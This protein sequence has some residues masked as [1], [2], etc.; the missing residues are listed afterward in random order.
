MRF[1][2]P[3]SKKGATW[4]K[5]FVVNRMILR[6]G[7]SSGIPCSLENFQNDDTLLGRGAVVV[8]LDGENP[9]VFLTFSPLG[10]QDNHGV[11][12]HA[13]RKRSDGIVIF[14][15]TGAQREQ[16]AKWRHGFTGKIYIELYKN[17]PFLASDYEERKEFFGSVVLNFHSDTV[18]SKVFLTFS[19]LSSAERSAHS[20]ATGNSLRAPRMTSD[21]IIQ[22][23]MEKE[24]DGYSK[25]KPPLDSSAGCLK[26][27][28]SNDG[29]Q[30]EPRRS[31]RLAQKHKIQ[32]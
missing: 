19:T 14:E 3:A 25:R 18:D 15:S 32:Q 30:S 13:S 6:T 1:Y 12:L 7:F 20:P 29:Y 31:A 22:E 28:L 9:S 4:P 21:T 8:R 10:P 2:V 11:N 24:K 5:T 16:G 27:K 26:R 23:V 17:W